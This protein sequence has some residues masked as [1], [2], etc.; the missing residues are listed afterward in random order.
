M[1]LKYCQNHIKFKQSGTPTQ[2]CVCLVM[3]TI[4]PIAQFNNSKI[5]FRAK[6][7]HLKH[8]FVKFKSLN[9]KGNFVTVMTLIKQCK[10]LVSFRF[11]TIISLFEQKY[12]FIKLVFNLIMSDSENDYNSPLPPVHE[13]LGQLRPSRELLEYY[14]KKV[15]EFDNEHDD[16]LKKLQ[17]YKASYEDQHRMELELTQREHEIADLQKAISDLQVNFFIFVQNFLILI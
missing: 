9:K 7:L 13:R 15:A 3:V 14:R 6:K 5:L 10:F 11:G 12:N 8:K 17:K 16:M 2:C 4:T 1:L